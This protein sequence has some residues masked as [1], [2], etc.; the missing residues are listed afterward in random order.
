M[1]ADRNTYKGKVVD[2]ASVWVCGSYLKFLPFTPKAGEIVKPEDYKHLIFTP[3]ISD[4]GKER[5]IRVFEVAE[6]TVS[7]CT[8][9]KD[10]TGRVIFEND[11]VLVGASLFVVVWAG[12]RFALEA[13]NGVCAEITDDLRIEVKGNILEQPEIIENLQT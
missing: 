5:G 11:I 9:L 8:G 2:R 13:P 6:E 12:N 1:V 4:E 3:D 7:Q 10:C